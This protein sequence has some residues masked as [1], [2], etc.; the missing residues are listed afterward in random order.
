MGEEGG[1]PAA[2]L[3]GWEVMNAVGCENTFPPAENKCHGVMLMK[4]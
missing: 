3:P 2:E 4:G 1:G